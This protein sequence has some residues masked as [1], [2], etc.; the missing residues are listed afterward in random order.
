MLASVALL[1]LFSTTVKSDADSWTVGKYAD[2]A[3]YANNNKFYECNHIKGRKK[4]VHTEFDLEKI[5]DYFNSSK[6]FKPIIASV[7][8]F[9]LVQPRPARRRMV[10]VVL[11]IS[12][13]RHSTFIMRKISPAGQ[14]VSAWIPRQAVEKAI[15]YKRPLVVHIGCRKKCIIPDHSKDNADRAKLPVLGVQVTRQRLMTEVKGSTERCKHKFELINLWVRRKEDR[16][17][18][19]GPSTIRTLSCTNN[20]LLCNC[21]AIDREDIYVLYVP[22]NGTKLTYER[23]QYFTDKSKCICQ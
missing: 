5:A 19:L 3:V 23:E 15:T 7:R 20:N 21:R 11:K 17:M 6:G 16:R 2:F 9:L 4:Y 1:F 22:F 8:L 14:W 12:G 18:F 13:V 10:K